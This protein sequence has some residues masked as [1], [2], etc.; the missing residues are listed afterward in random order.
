MSAK[1]G[2]LPKQSYSKKK[3]VGLWWRCQSVWWDGKQF[4]KLIKYLVQLCTHEKIVQVH[5][6][7][8]AEVIANH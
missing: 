6:M 3:G 4:Y 8:T 5:E 7:T 2:N 1:G